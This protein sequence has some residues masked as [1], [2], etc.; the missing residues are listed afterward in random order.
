MAA[1]IVPS[2][3][4]LSA[5][6]RQAVGIRFTA[7]PDA[8]GEVRFGRVRFVP[9]DPSVPDAHLSYVVRPVLS[10]DP[11]LLRVTVDRSE[12]RPG[13]LLTYTL[14]AHSPSVGRATLGSVVDVLPPGLE[15]VEGSA[16]ARPQ[17]TLTTSEWVYEQGQLGWA[18]IF[19]PATAS[20]QVAAAAPVESFI[21]LGALGIE[22][23]PC[24]PRCDESG[25]PVEG[26]ALRYFGRRYERAIVSTNG[27][28]EVGDASGDFARFNVVRLPNPASA[29]NLV[30]PLWADFDLGRGG[31]MYAGI[32]SPDG[33]ATEFDVISWEQVA[34]FR[35]PAGVTDPRYSFQ[36]WAQRNAERLLFVYG[37]VPADPDP[38]SVGFEGP[39]GAVGASA[40]F[41]GVGEL[42]V[43][44]R[45]LEAQTQPAGSAQLQFQ[46]RVT[47][48]ALP[49]PIVNRAQLVTPGAR[50]VA[51]AITELGLPD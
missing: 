39:S 12:A 3:F 13:D 18:G 19:Q 50:H 1:E 51:S 33:G 38:G 20:L 43:E 42:P 44:G 11:E 9:D 6:Q 36:V 16:R 15:L 37:R 26:L 24:A 14:H 8:S 22:P 28:L 34:L 21:S 29:N 25:I 35:D 41:D 2:E 47:E 5:S 23:L 17:N 27:A 30:A 48:A 46:V 10:R 7:G 45:V 32:V 4:S 31:A 49:G 40:Y